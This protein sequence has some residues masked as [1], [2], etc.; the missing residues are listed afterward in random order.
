MQE[1]AKTKIVATIGPAAW[2]G[3]TLKKMINAGMQVARINA[4]FADYEEIVRVSNQIREISPRITIMLDTKGFKIR[5]TGF[6]QEIPLKKDQQVI[7]ASESCNHSGAIKITYPNLERDVLP[8]TRVLLD[9]GTIQL[10]VT[11]VEGELI[12]CKVIQEGVL[13]PKKTVNIPSINLSFPAL[14][15]KDKTDIEYAVKQN[16]DYVA[17]SFVRN[18]EDILQVKQITGDSPIKIIAKIESQEG[19]EN[20]DEI[21]KEADGIM[22]ARGDL[23]VETPLVKVPILQKQM[24]YKCRAAGK[25]VIVATQMLESMRE[26]MLPTRAEVSDVANAVM[27]GTDAVMLSAETSTG[28]YPVQVIQKMTE[29]AKAAEDAMIPSPIYGHTD[30]TEEID[31]LCKQVFDL[32]RALNLKGVVVLSRTGRTVASL[33][34]HRLDI[35][36]WSV[37][38]NFI[39]LRQDGFLRG[40]KTYL[41]KDL[42]GDKD[43]YTEKAVQ[44]VYSNGELDLNDKIAIISGSSVKHRTSNAI[45]EI[46]TVKDTL[47]RI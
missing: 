24:I 36:I 21:L 14:T 11:R 16:L 6:D 45:L 33:S 25:P 34:R 7:I 35:P 2:E 32:S 26:N 10:E 18:R 19:I 5:V 28:K 20:F 1:F 4:S 23:G 37:C 15:E 41:V 17:M 13:K 30:A 44:A 31:E 29:I 9:D 39:R 8:G 38:Q 46:A 3:D 27:D 43:T 22:V 40:V 42:E 47:S 12:Y